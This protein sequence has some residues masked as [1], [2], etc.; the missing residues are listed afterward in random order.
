MLICCVKRFSFL[1]NSLLQMHLIKLENYEGACAK[2]WRWALEPRAPFQPCTTAYITANSLPPK[3]HGGLKQTGKPPTR[4]NPQLGGNYGRNLSLWSQP[5]NPKW[6][7]QHSIQPPAR[8]ATQEG[9][10]LSGP[11][12]HLRVSGRTLKGTSPAS[13]EPL[14]SHTVSVFS[15]LSSGHN[16]TAQNSSILSEIHPRE[17]A[18]Q[19]ADLFQKF[20]ELLDRGLAQ[21][22]AKITGDL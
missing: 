8:S 13:T 9:N 21:T 17:Q 20:S 10:L 2:L 3:S 15:H 12:L 11:K 1:L 16:S 19:M 6:P 4:I 5:K 22:A 14:I 7:P 18:H